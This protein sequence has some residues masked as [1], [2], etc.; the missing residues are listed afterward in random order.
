[1][2][3]L[4]QNRSVEAPTSKG[5]SWPFAVGHSRASGISDPVASNKV[6]LPAP[7]GRY[8]HEICTP[9]DFDQ[10]ALNLLT[11]QSTRSTSNCWR[12]GATCIDTSSPS[13]LPSMAL[14]KGASLL[15]T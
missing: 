11:A 6:V 4:L 15:M 10:L 8:V 9:A 12:I 14:P 13:H 2:D 7:P 5:C 1:M 3:R